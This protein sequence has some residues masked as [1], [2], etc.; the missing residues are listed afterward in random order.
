MKIIDLP[1][2]TGFLGLL[3]TGF[4]LHL[5]GMGLYFG[6]F[7]DGEVSML[8]IVLFEWDE[9]SDSGVMHLCV[10]RFRVLYFLFSLHLG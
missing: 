4:V 9:D 3:W 6:W 5:K 10:F 7:P 8:E 2:E 1:N